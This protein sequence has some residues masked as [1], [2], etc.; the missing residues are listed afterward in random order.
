MT[1]INQPLQ[2]MNEG[3]KNE[4]ISDPIRIVLRSNKVGGYDQI[5]KY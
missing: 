1:T 5:I 4:A 2:S 3:V